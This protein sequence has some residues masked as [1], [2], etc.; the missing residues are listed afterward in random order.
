MPITMKS[1]SCQST[2]CS[3]HAEPA[4]VVQSQFNKPPGGNSLDISIKSFDCADCAQKLEQAL[5]KIP[6][7]VSVKVNFIS[8]SAH[9]IYDNGLVKPAEIIT[10]IQ[11]LGYQAMLVEANAAG[12]NHNHPKTV[13]S[14][15][16]LKIVIIGLM[17]GIMLG[18]ELLELLPSAVILINIIIIS[19]GG[20]PIAKRG[21]GNLRNRII[22]TNLLMLIAITGAIAIGEWSEAATVVFLSGIGNYLQEYT[23]G[24]TRQSIRSLMELTPPYAR[25]LRN[26]QELRLPVEDITIGEVILVKPGEMVPLD[27]RVQ[28]GS[29]AVN[30]ASITGESIPV[31]KQTGDDVY[32]GTMNMQGV[33]EVVVTKFAQDTTAAKIIKLIE[34]AQNKKATAEL[35]VD[36][37]ARFYTPIV[38]SL[39]ICLV[40]VP[41]VVFQQSFVSWFYRALVLLVI[42]C[43]CALVISTPVSIISAIGNAS[44]QGIL[45]KGGEYIEQLGKVEN[46]AFDKTGT[47]TMGRLKV[48]RVECTGNLSE[49][50]ILNI[51][52]TVEKY[53]EHPIAQAI[54][55]EE[56]ATDLV[57]AVNF[58]AL[59]GQGA[60]ADIDDET[61]YVG[62]KRLFCGLGHNL[63]QY[64]TIWREIELNGETYVLVGTNNIL[65]GIICLADVVNS[66]GKQVIAELKRYGIAPLM[67]TG[68]NE[69]AAK[70]V[71]KAVNIENYYSDLMP[72]NKADIIAR[73]R[74]QGKVV[75]MVG[76]GVNDA[77]ALAEAT[78]GIAM[79]ATGSDT[80]LETADVALMTNDLG[81]I[82]YAVKLS[83]NTVSIIKQNIWIAVGL[84][85]IFIIGTVIGVTNLWL[86]VFADVGAS[87][88]VTVNG[89][90]LLAAKKI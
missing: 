66:S 90:R 68:D 69:Y 26:G 59:P 86:A 62:N 19:F 41:T 36:K 50:Q 73:L 31:D 35:I 82:S 57:P 47:L 18:L 13:F 6:G 1:C 74:N 64:E 81:K 87:I 2:A 70:T 39:A 37:F 60:S 80:A 3:S 9:I 40:V 55:T 22:D 10:F 76:D 12:S 79:G 84:K 27:G 49:Q 48:V 15:D 5:T 24:K 85:V 89:M 21:I 29:S 75:A 52:A 38:I 88:I 23:L 61:I 63:E 45:I 54:V 25:V 71:A 16:T 72:E 20:Y 44:R 53:S 65:Y 17:W 4:G 78:V 46:I 51:A 56:A 28:C 42:S 11:K 43:P 58:I 77:P 7:I 8:E 83:R 32:A 33:L 67:L 14:G 34:Q 30:Q